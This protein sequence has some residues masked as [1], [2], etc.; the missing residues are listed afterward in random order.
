MKFPHFMWMALFF[1]VLISFSS[2]AWLDC[3]PASCASGYTDN[4]IYCTGGTC[5]RN[6]SAQVCDNSWIQ[7]H[8]DTAFGINEFNEDDAQAAS[9]SYTPT[10]TSRCY[11]FVFDGPAAS[12][13]NILMYVTDSPPTPPG[14]CDSE[15]IG[16]FYQ[17]A[18][19]WFSSVSGYI[20]TQDN[21]FASNMVSSMRVHSETDS[22]AS[23]ENDASQG[24]YIYCAPNTIAC[25]YFSGIRGCDI[26]CYNVAT[27]G[28]VVQGYYEDN[29]AGGSGPPNTTLY[30]GDRCGNAYCGRNLLNPAN[31]TVYEANATTIN[32]SDK[33]CDRINEA[34]TVSNVLVLPLNPT[35]GQDLLCNY[36]Y[37]DIE[38][39]AEQSSSYQWFKNTVNQNIN[40]SL[41]GKGNLTVSDSWYCKVA[42]G[43]GLI[44]GSY[45]Q[46]SNT[47]SVTSTVQNV[48]F[49]VNAISIWSYPGFFAGPETIYNFTDGLN[50]ALDTCIADADGFCTINL[51]FF[52]G[53]AG[54]NSLSRLG[55]YY[56][57]QNNPPTHTTP[58]L[59]S[60]KLLTNDTNQ[61]LT[62][63]F[64]NV[65]DLDGDGVKNITDWRVNGSSIAVLNMPF[66]GGSSANFTRD[67]S[68]Y[69]LNGSVNGSYYNNSGGYDRRGAYSFNGI[70]NSILVANAPSLQINKTITITFWVNPNSNTYWQ[71]LVTKGNDDAYSTTQYMTFLGSNG[72]V[73]LRISNTTEFFDR[74]SATTI[75]TSTWTFVA[76]VYNG[77]N[78]SIYVNGEVDNGV[79]IGN[80]GGTFIPGTLQNTTANVYVGRQDR[81]N[82]PYYFNGSFDEVKIYSRAL[83][84]EQIRILFQNRTDL[85]VAQETTIGDNWT[86]SVT[87]NDGSVDG[88]SLLSN[89]VQILDN[90]VPT[91]T[92]PLLNSTNPASNDTN[93]N[94]TLY[95]SVTE[96]DNDTV[97]NIIVWRV[98]STPFANFIMPFEG[99][100]NTPFNNAWDYSGYGNN[101]SEQGGIAWN[102]SGGYDQR[103]AYQFDGVDDSVLIG[104]TNS[105]RITGPITI[106]SWIRINAAPT[107][108]HFIISKGDD[109]LHGTVAYQTFIDTSNRFKFK[110]A[111]NSEFFTRESA[112]IL[113][114][115]V[116]AHVAAVYNRTNMS[117]YVN[118]VLDNGALTGNLGGTIIPSTLQDPTVNLYIGRQDRVA[119]PRFFNGVIDDVAIYNRSL[120]AEQ[121]YALFT[122]RTT[123]ITSPETNAWDNWTADVIPND[124]QADG[125]VSRSNQLIILPNVPPTHTVPILNSTNPATNDTNQNLTLYPQNV[126]D[127]NGDSVKNIMGWKI[128]GAPI[129]ALHMPFEGGSNSTF[130]R[131][132]SG[133][134]NN[135]TVINA[136]WN[137]AGGY[138]RKGAYTFDG[139][140][141]LINLSNP[142]PLQ[143]TGNLTL[144]AWIKP[145][146]TS[147]L[148]YIISKGDDDAFSTV[149]Y[150]LFTGTSSDKKIYFRTST[151]TGWGM[152]TSSTVLNSNV[153]YHI[154]GM[155]VPNQNV[156]I[157]INGVLDN[158]VLE[159]SIPSSLQNPAGMNLYLGAQQRE[160]YP[161]YFNGT[162]DEVK[163]Y[164]RSLSSEQ[165]GALYNN[166]TDLIVS[167]E[168]EVGQVWSAEVTP[169]DGTADGATL[170]SNQLIVN[171]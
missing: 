80:L 9:T 103:G 46:S 8:T 2:L 39:Y 22:D 44:I 145:N 63:Y 131:D 101:G 108:M 120:S 85:L 143:I 153:W 119:Y 105:I 31:F 20:G 70:N 10:N 5:Y 75:P 146:F 59:N 157:Y 148:Q 95:V 12:P 166:R 156:D 13:N 164:N 124:G 37:I 69:A 6:C 112:S 114:T 142:T 149:A 53:A 102:S 82:N 97:K 48:I 24:G 109:D 87:P 34:A 50:S 98:N 25:G 138:D 81:Q 60:T 113:T 27:Q 73:G 57:T 129:M 104:H 84:A 163:I 127:Q 19:P 137:S 128:G 135:G 65:S 14:D 168:T 30:D 3:T 134:G 49:Y 68:L 15:A 100:N 86:V 121:I 94:L 56:L 169:N 21:T 42:P 43:D 110:I 107:E 93:T 144:E 45:T 23:Y 167:Q 140:G 28:K 125:N 40:N 91:Q 133:F 161:R 17:G 99:I 64:Q 159:G 66:E 162:I 90:R 55:I 72:K 165:I 170:G 106:I 52:S 151:G 67:Y 1:L 36:T 155:Y 29:V 132:Y 41:L 130:T 26:D 160:L 16:G 62:L 126:Q 18:T 33:S 141:D 171:Q 47:I 77:T 116:W 54:N 61:N 35:A 118:G 152:R 78:M 89:Q 4:G 32:Q 122:N 92:Q 71:Y 123:I 150:Q 79:L 11:Q 136:I 115:G 96:P 38:G 154:V 158:G 147:D 58:L 51:T 111:N 76:A 7:V 83:S 74:S 88:A 139:Q 117:V